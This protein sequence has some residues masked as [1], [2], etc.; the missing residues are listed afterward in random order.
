MVFCCCVQDFYVSASCRNGWNICY[1]E[2]LYGLSPVWTLMWVFRCPDSL[3]TFSHTWH[4][5]GFSPLWILLCLTRS[6]AFVNRLLQT[7]HSNGFS[8]EWIRLCIARFWLLP[9]HWPHSVHLHLPLWIFIC[10]HRP[11]L[12]EMRFSHWVHEYKFS[13]VCF[14]LWRFKWSFVVNRLS[15]TPQVNWTVFAHPV[16]NKHTTCLYLIRR[17]ICC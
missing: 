16:W 5:Y 15:H 10:T 2:H 9:Q 6:P 17:S 3:N 4:S 7:V 14:F 1:S 13:P 8:P 12:E 11:F